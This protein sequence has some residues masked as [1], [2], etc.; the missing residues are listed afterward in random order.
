MTFVKSNNL[1][2]LALLFGLLLSLYTLRI[3]APPD[4]EG[5]AQHRNVGYVMDAVWNGNWLAQYDIQGR[6]TSKPPLHT[7]L[8]AGLA[9][10][11]GVNRL[12]LTLPSLLGIGLL[13][14]LVFRVGGRHL[15]RS[16][17]FWAAFALLMAPMV[18]K[19]ISL[20]RSDSLFALATACCAFAAW[21]AWVG[22]KSWTPFWL[23]GALATLIKGPLGLL[24]GAAGLLA[25]FWERRTSGRATPALKG[26]HF[27][28]I[29]LFLGL[30]L[31]WFLLALNSYGQEL[32][33]KVILDELIGQATGGPKSTVP[34]SNLL[35]P[36]FYFVIRFIP[37]SLFAIGGL[38]RVF[39]APAETAEERL[40]ERFLTCWFLAGMVLF[41]LAAHHRADL[42]LPL[43]PAAALLAGREMS[44]LAHHIGN[45]R[46]A[47]CTAL[48]CVF[49]L[50]LTYL[51]YHQMPDKRDRITRYSMTARDAALALRKTSLDPQ[52]LQHLDTP[53]SFQMHL[54]THHRWV[55]PKALLKALAETDGEMLIAVENHERFAELFNEHSMLISR[56]VFRW[57]VA[58][59]N[60]FISIFS[61][62]RA[63]EAFSY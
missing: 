56:E 33:D 40:F 5:Y 32:F 28:G 14:L 59:E 43:W 15:G 62:R 13:V 49:L 61:L 60:P 30:G 45:L 11:L 55:E 48:A 23:A 18:S 4:L 46:A 19:H 26:S 24:L 25:F 10:F 17:G 21:R 58:A 16:A 54:E 31:G 50:G 38:L 12:S 37:F 39:R 63:P 57:P 7:W 47:W 27:F 52:R 51:N 20:A 9:L 42:L 36:S 35:K 41:S 44:R 6:I 8:S 22:G 1:L 34:G 3:T 29:V 53:V 2:L